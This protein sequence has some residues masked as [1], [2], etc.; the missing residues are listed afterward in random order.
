MGQ[1]DSPGEGNGN[2]L[3]YSCLVNPMDRGARWATIHRVAQSQ[4]QL[5]PLSAHAVLKI[6]RNDIFYALEWLLDRDSEKAV[7]D[8]VY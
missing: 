8:S 1:E 3:Q 6:K 7:L 5:K 2:P 4:T